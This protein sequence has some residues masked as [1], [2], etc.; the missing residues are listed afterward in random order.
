MYKSYPYANISSN[1]S[2]Y[3][4]QMLV[5]QKLQ[6][7]MV[8]SLTVQ[9][10]FLFVFCL[11]CCGSRPGPPAP[12]ASASPPWPLALCSPTAYLDSTRCCALSSSG[13]LIMT[14]ATKV[15]ALRFDLMLSLC[16]K[17][18]FFIMIK[19]PP[20]TFHSCHKHVIVTRPCF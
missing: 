18:F 14:H 16:T 11:W 3:Y 12:Q 2:L 1:G 7:E 19:K 4:N 8:H 15:Q 20:S 10:L 9:Q 13:L 17:H 6:I 5:D